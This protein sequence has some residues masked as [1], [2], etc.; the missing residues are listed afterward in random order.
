[1]AFIFKDNRRVYHHPDNVEASYIAS[2]ALEVRNYCVEAVWL[3]LFRLCCSDAMAVESW[4]KC[5][6]AGVSLHAGLWYCTQ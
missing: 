4:N 2:S 5:S 3:H 6:L 1:M